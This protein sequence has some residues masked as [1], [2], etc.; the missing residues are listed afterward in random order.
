MHGLGNDFILVDGR[1][2]LPGNPGEIA[3]KI[4]D[5]HTGVGADGLIVAVT[6]EMADVGMRIYNADGSE[7]EMCG[8][9]IRCFARFVFE[10]KMV[11]ST[12]FT[13]E[14]LAGIM[15]PVLITGDT[16]SVERVV[17][18]MGI[19]V[20]DSREIPVVHQS[21]RFINVPVSIGGKHYHLSAIRM[22]VPHTVVYVDDIEAVDIAGVGAAI[23]KHPLFPQKTNVNMVQVINSK[24]LRVRTWERGVGVTLACGTGCCASA[25]ISH[26]TGRVDA[27]RGVEVELPLGIMTVRWDQ[28]DG[29]VYM[30]GPAENICKGIWLEDKK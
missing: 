2:N 19:P 11:A 17:V 29:H 16:G 10:E 21:E 9:G 24:R 3:I 28:R 22:G 20:M 15:Q 5:R 23:E 12:E 30:E 7:A 27:R 13:V 25:V 18:D 4:C 6:S 14:T 1:D 8:N 26:I